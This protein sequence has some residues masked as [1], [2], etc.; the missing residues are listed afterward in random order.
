MFYVY[1]LRSEKTGRRYVGSCEDVEQ[2]LKRHN[3]AHSKA[4]ATAFRGLSYIPK[5][6]RHAAKRCGASYFIKPAADARL[7]IN[8]NG[9]PVAAATGRGFKSRRPDSISPQPRRTQR[10]SSVRQLINDFYASA[11]SVGYRLSASMAGCKFRLVLHRWSA[12]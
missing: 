10:R 3:A 11:A 12:R 5:H 7:S 2:R 1:V 9:R 8:S 4:T 6:L